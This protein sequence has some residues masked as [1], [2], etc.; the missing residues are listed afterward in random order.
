MTKRFTLAA[1]AGLLLSAPVLMA[2]QAPQAGA[3]LQVHLT[4]L[5]SAK[6]VVH[7]CLSARPDK[8]LDCKADKTALAR[9]VPARAA[10]RLDLG[11]V[12]PGT[13]ALLIVHDENQNGKLDMTLGIPREGFGFSNNPAMRPRPPRWEEIRFTM[14]A[15]PTTQQIRV[16]YV[17]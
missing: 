7:L 2:A 14:P 16:R 10:G 3:D 5:R 13:Y 12:R 9:T 11:P 4:G 15:T 6:G 17:L 8:F 1:T